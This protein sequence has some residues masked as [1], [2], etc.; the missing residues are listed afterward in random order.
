VSDSIGKS[1][2]AILNAVVHKDYAS[3]IPIQLS[4]Y[5]D[6]LVIWNP[7]QLPEA[8]TLDDLQQKHPSQPF[9]PDI[10]NTFFRAGEIEAWGR[11]IERIFEACRKAETPE[12]ELRL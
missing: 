6:R 1:E 4:V 2:K 12:P 11:G 9:N 7:G 3:G 5:D 10:A 8:W